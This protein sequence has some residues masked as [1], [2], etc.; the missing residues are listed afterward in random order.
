MSRGGQG[1]RRD[2]QDR[3]DEELISDMFMLGL[4]N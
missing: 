2:R 4:G 3:S 1:R